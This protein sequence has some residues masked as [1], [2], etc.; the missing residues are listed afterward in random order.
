MLKKIDAGFLF[1]GLVLIVLI[2]SCSRSMFGIPA[3]GKFLNPFIGSVQNEKAMHKNATVK[4]GTAKEVKVS[5][6]SRNVPHIFA[7]SAKDM[8]MAQGY[9]V[10]TD[11]LWQMDFLSYSAAGRLSEILGGNLVTYDRKQRRMGLL[12]AAR[13]SLEVME[14]DPMTKEALDA[15]TAGV[16]KFIDGLSYK[17]LPF[18]YKLLDYKPE[19]W[20]NLKSAL[21]LKFMGDQLSGFEEDY[22]MTQMKLALGNKQFKLLFPD[23]NY[24]TSTIAP[25]AGMQTLKPDSSAY[26]DYI[27]YSFLTTFPSIWTASNMQKAG[28]R[29]PAYASNCWAISAKKSASGKPI[30]CNDPHLSLTLP[31]IW[32]EVQLSNGNNNVYGVSIPGTPGVIIGFNNDIAWGV[33]NGTTDVKDWYK[34]KIKNDYSAYEFNNEWL[35]PTMT[36]ETIKVKGG[37][38]ITDTCY[39]TIHGPIV[40]DNFYNLGMPERQNYALRWTVLEPSNEFSAFLQLNNAKD[41]KDFEN[42]LRGYKSPVQ[43]FTFAGRN[44][45]IAMRHQGLLYKKFPGEGKFFLDGTKK[46]HY[47]DSA[48]AFEQLPS[49]YNPESGFV[50]SANNRPQQKDNNNYLTGRYAETRANGIKNTLEQAKQFTV[51]DMQKMQL[52]NTNQVAKA[53]LPIMLKNLRAAGINDKRVE[54][55]SGWN[56]QYTLT[57]TLAPFFEKWLWDVKTF[58]WDELASY[59]FFFRSPDD[60]VLLQLMTFDS[61]NQVFDRVNSTQKETAKDIIAASYKKISEQ[62]N[63]GKT[64]AWGKVHTPSLVHLSQQ[65]SLS[66]MNIQAPGYSEALNAITTIP[67]QATGWGPSWRMIVE[68]GDK[69]QAWGIYAGGQSGNP[70]SKDYDAFVNDWLTGKYYKLNFYASL[71]EAQKETKYSWT[72]N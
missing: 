5:F 28:Q 12:Q 23:Y 63:N 15:Y 71:A 22:F 39:S 18:E 4:L 24:Y 55:L 60:Y 66:R 43:N 65:T 52:D 50:Y 54:A 49:E 20:T 51:E 13:K 29:Q 72:L 70:G 17:S 58:T 69:P 8:Y 57:D 37:K 41:Y 64:E 3:L 19:P 9:T 35:K 16:N 21:I 42:A 47:Y 44:G 68:M 67:G 14:K 27:N 34:L 26:C 33:T 2:F 38:T 59:P 45:D 10:A 6:D 32:Y 48:V 61:A 62:M 31:A 40:A 25:Q 11:R 46:E 30:L 1:P 7:G 56:C 36:L 53:M